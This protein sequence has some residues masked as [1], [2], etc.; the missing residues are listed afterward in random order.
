MRKVG[1]KGMLGLL[2]LFVVLIIY[3]VWD[4][5]R[6]IVVEQEIVIEHLPEGFDGFTILQITDLHERE[7]GK[8]QASLIEKVNSVKYD[9]IVFTGDMLDS[10]ASTN[11][12]PF[13]QLIEGIHNKTH[14]LYVPG[15]A[16][17]NNYFL[18]PTRP[19]EKDEFIKGMEHRG[20]KLLESIYT[21]NDEAGAAIQFVEFDI[22]VKNKEIYLNRPEPN[23]EAY[24][25]YM[26]HQKQLFDEME[27]LDKSNVTIALSHYPIVDRR[28]DY[29][30]SS[31]QFMFRQFDLL[32]AG[33]YHGGQIRLPFIGALFVPEPWYD[34]RGIL[35]PRD[36]VKG[37][38]EYRGI[39]QYVSTGLGS[40]DAI[41]MLR[42]R[43]LNPP[44]INI[45]TL[46]K[47]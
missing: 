19:F 35:P 22:A 24:K 20:V 27:S 18:H 13:Y 40:S 25:A 36:R 28:I 8:N 23:N 5:Q 6:I 41:P 12:R 26:D 15:N 42:F 38:W 30:A 37:L 33:H 4:N 21:I 3:T 43:F 46:K 16:D 7:F 1:G 14:A 47:K 32:L 44:E 11:Y 29:M 45:L 34:R 31:P 10:N 9:A 17:P 39:Q 2:L